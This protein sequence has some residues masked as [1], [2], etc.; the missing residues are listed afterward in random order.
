M[1]YNEAPEVTFA[2]W[3]REQLD[4]RGWGIR[5]LA[6][7]IDPVTPEVPRRA[8][9]RYMRGS[10]PT[11]PYALAIAT[12]LGVP[13]ED[14]PI[15]EAAPNGDPFRGRPRG[16]APRTRRDTAGAAQAKGAGKTGELAA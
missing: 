13:R 5:T 14:M 3:L 2:E 6:R 4:E 9:N 15:E 7:K 8:L 1:G 16:S 10:H 12:A 11:E